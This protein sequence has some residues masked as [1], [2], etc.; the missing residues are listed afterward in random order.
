M[1]NNLYVYDLAI[2]VA[3]RQVLEMK[4]NVITA[5]LNFSSIFWEVCQD[6]RGRN[7]Y[8]AV[9]YSDHS[10]IYLQFAIADIKTLDDDDLERRIIAGGFKEP[11]TT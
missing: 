9:A 11:P 5:A 10:Q 8:R 6:L 4:K 2:P 7:Y 3:D 1:C